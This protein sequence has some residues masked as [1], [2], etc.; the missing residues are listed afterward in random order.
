MSILELAMHSLLSR[1]I[2]VTFAFPAFANPLLETAVS[3]FLFC[4]CFSS[5][6]YEILLGLV[7][8]VSKTY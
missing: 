5:Y 8:E 2:R 1:L 3:E 7:F 4:E 6:I